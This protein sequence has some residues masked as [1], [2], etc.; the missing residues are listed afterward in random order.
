MVAKFQPIDI[1]TTC[2]PKVRKKEIIFLRFVTYILI[3]TYVFFFV[4]LKKER[5]MLFFR[6]DYKNR[7]NLLRNRGG[8]IK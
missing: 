8:V 2:I 3:N 6:N 7:S 5:N 4:R 1:L